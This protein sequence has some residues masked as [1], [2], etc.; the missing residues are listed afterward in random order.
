MAE[1]QKQTWGFL[2]EK[3]SLPVD[4]PIDEE[5]VHALLDPA[6]EDDEE[7][8]PEPTP[9][10][11]QQS[12]A[13]P[14]LR[15]STLGNWMLGVVADLAATRPA[16]VM[17]AARDAKRVGRF[18]PTEA[19]TGTIGQERTRRPSSIQVLPHSPDAST[20]KLPHSAHMIASRRFSLQFTPISPTYSNQSMSKG[21]DSSEMR[22]KTLRARRVRWRAGHMQLGR[23]ERRLGNGGAL[24]ISYPHF[25]QGRFQAQG[26]FSGSSTRRPPPEP[27][28]MGDCAWNIPNDPYKPLF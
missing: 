28:I 6:N 15:L 14:A 2:P 10:M 9:D 7:A 5:E 17:V 8:R 13:C 11:K 12:L 3:S 26:T 20:V 18:V 25:R 19:F 22:R 4:F 23:G 1:A 27:L 16:S 21:R 24:S